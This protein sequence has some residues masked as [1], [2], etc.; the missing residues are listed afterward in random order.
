MEPLISIRGVNHFFG[1][2]PLRKQILFDVSADILPGEIV[3]NT[4]PSGSGKT[5]L[6]TLA[7][8]LR[9]VQEG[10]LRVL[11]QELYQAEAPVL[12][13]VRRNIGF[14]FQAHNLLR[15]L[16]ACQNVE[17]ALGLDPSLGPK[18][19]RARAVAM[20][21][22][23]GLGARLDYLPQQLS[24]GQKQRVAIA[25]ALVAK[26]QIILADEP[27]AALDRKSGREVVEILHTL[28]KTQGC[29]IL[30]VT[31]DNRILDI[32]DRIMTLEDGRIS[33]FSS[34]MTAETGHLLGA[35]S[36]MQRKGELTRHV[37]ALSDQKFV[38][39]LEQVTAEFE[40]FLRTSELASRD[41]IEAL[42]DQ[43]LEA[44]ARRIRGMLNADRATLYLYDAEKEELRSRIAHSDGSVPLEIRI[45]A[46]RGIA[47]RVARTAETM[48]IPDAYAHPDFDPATDKETG[49]K[50]RTILCMPVYD[51]RKRVFAVAQLLNKRNGEPFTTADE[52]RFLEF[53]HPLGILLESC[54]R[55]GQTG[56]AAPSASTQS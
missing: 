6:L 17:M 46:H 36:Q 11:N 21:E 55:L 40:Q 19:T 9:S 23:V 56:S 24:G 15:S 20:L 26:P 37:D 53:A 18:E 48:N 25:R 35:F 16:T 10:S 50:T 28:A 32:A 2:G 30:L 45:S 52:D 12:A 39:A 44:A 42:G 47:G 4:G 1:T 3:I 27:T 49:Y 13:R 31:H 33:S 51:R 29:A 22:S 14:M 7:G 43:V 5:T 34:G 8:A 41:A 54:S 38:E